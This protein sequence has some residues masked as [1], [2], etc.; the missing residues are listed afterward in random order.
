LQRRFAAALF[1][2]DHEMLCAELRG[3][4]GN[5]R[6]R[7]D[8]YR[9]QL[10]A[11]FVRTLA[12][13]FP[14][15]ERLVGGEYFRRLGREFQTAHPSRAGDLQ[16]IGAPFAA[17]LK[18]R[19]AGGPYDYLADVAALEWAVQECLIAPEAPAFAV[20]TLQSIA[21]DD[22][23]QLHLE[24]HPAC[25]VVSSGYP[26]LQIWRANQSACA[27][28]QSIDLASG[29]TRVL[30]QRR[31][32][33]VVFHLLSASELA[34]CEKIAQDFSLATALAAAQRWEA[35]FDLGAALRRLIA[36]HAL[37]AFRLGRANA[38]PASR[39]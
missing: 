22:Y 24:F 19:F 36:W 10:H 38:L 4:G 2:D 30:V 7:V 26:T 37:T 29:A 17:F 14:V 16:H 13:E 23:A 25:R 34:L 3:N 32:A 27:P 15:I 28:T 20:H 39:I 12:L 21:A 9:H 5:A 33:G 18:Q 8:L 1:A 6:A 11:A 35:A 31:V